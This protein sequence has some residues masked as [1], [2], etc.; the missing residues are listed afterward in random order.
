MHEL[1][2]AQKK[3]LNTVKL[4]VQRSTFLRIFLCPAY[5]EEK[6]SVNICIK[7]LV[8][9]ILGTEMPVLRGRSG[10]VLPPENV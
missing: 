7:S 2:N 3:L 6:R 1:F 8:F 10:V 5:M 9:L 4:I